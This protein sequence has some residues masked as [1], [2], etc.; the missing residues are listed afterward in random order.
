VLVDGPT[1][2]EVAAEIVA[3]PG[4][5]GRIEIRPT[6][7]GTKTIP[8]T[9]E[10][11]ATILGAVGGVAGLVD[12][13][14]QIRLRRAEKNATNEKDPQRADGNRVIVYVDQRALPLEQADR[15]SLTELLEDAP[16]L[17]SDS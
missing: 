3:M 12:T 8:E 16:P 13:L 14:L 10:A 5:Q 11:V 17:D 7:A 15:A 6:P 4:I 1:A 9:V 2:R